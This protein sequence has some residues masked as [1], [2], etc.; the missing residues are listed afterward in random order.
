MAAAVEEL[1][2]DVAT[3]VLRQLDA[4]SL[5]AASCA[6]T[7]L[8]RLAGQ[9]CLWA[10]LCAATWPSVRDR[11][12]RPLLSK[13]FFTDTWTFPG[14]AAGEAAPPPPSLIS[15]VDL[16]R[17]GDRIFSTVIETDTRGGWFASAPFRVAAHVGGE[18]GEAAAAAAGELELS[19]IVVDPRGGR[20]VRVASRRAVAARRRGHVAATQVVFAVVICGGAAAATAAVEVAAAAVEVSLWVEDWRGVWLSGESVAAIGGAIGGGR[21]GG[22]AAAKAYVEFQKRRVEGKEKTADM[23]RKLD[24]ICVLFGVVLSFFFFLFFG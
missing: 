5:A 17:G 1:P 11:R 10:A 2:D 23:E 8:R 4:P 19:W 16:Y 20:G 15:A 21:V 7:W 24:L 9:R 12:L 13:E 18:A 6:T 22:G 3:L 14:G